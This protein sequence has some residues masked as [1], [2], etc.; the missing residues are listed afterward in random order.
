MLATALAYAVFFAVASLLV[1]LIIRSFGASNAEQLGSAINEVVNELVNFIINAQNQLGEMG[2]LS[3]LN[4]PI[5]DAI[6]AVSD[7]LKA[8]ILSLGTALASVGS[9]ALNLALGFIIGFYMLME[10]D[11]LLY[12]IWQLGRAFLPRHLNR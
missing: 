5:N 12:R 1:T 2:I 10:K 11:A 7:W 3:N 9:M 6:L 4:E 8:S